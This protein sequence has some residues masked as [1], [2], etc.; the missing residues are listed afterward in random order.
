MTNQLNINELNNIFGGQH[1]VTGSVTVDGQGSFSGAQGTYTYTS[2]DGYSAS[3][4]TSFDSQG[5]VSSV[6]IGVAA[7]F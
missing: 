2:K 1:S 4:T 5:S 3:G 6:G 7:E